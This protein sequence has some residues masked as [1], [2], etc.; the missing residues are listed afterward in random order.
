MSNRNVK[1]V[2]DGAGTD[3]NG[4]ALDTYGG[5]Y[6]GVLVLVKGGAAWDRAGTVYLETSP[7]GVTW[8][9]PA[10]T[11]G[12]TSGIRKSV[13][14]AAT[15]DGRILYDFIN[16]SHRY[17]RGRWDNTTAGTGGTIDV[18]VIVAGPV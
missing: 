13:A 18:Y 7:D 5:T 3:V 14:I 17:V 16:E 2:A 9:D 4:T 15:D 11:P 8:P 12:G 10:Q 6:I 1:S